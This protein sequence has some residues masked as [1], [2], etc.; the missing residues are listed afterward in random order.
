[1]RH[2]QNIFGPELKSIINDPQ[3]IDIVTK[4][5]EEIVIPIQ[6]AEFNIFNVEYKEN[7]EAVM[8][9]VHKLVQ[10]LEQKAKFFINM[11]FKILK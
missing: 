5:V 7:W 11:S 3:Q 6:I 1:M 8:M 2:F 10:I 9:E 4:Q